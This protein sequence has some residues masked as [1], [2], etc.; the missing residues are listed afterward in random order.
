[1]AAFTLLHVALSLVGI[2]SGFVLAAGFV[3]GKYSAGWNVT[4][5]ASNVLTDLTGFGFPTDKFL[6]SHA[7]AILSLVLLAIA[8]F[9]AYSRKLSGYWRPTFVITTTG[10]LYL[11]FFVLVVQAFLKV[12]ALQELAPTQSEL[13][14]AL[15]QGVTLLGFLVLGL[16]A[17]WGM[18]R[19][20][21]TANANYA[22]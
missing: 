8:M 21:R 20:V 5:L 18:K 10:A 13:P 14:F 15:A 3:R 22:T 2:V 16:T 12:P 11:N 1:M 9:A 17:V 6:P 7:F 4:F 19:M